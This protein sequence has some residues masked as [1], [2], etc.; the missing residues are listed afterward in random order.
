MNVDSMVIEVT[1]R[2]QLE[3]EHC[4]RG[5]AQSPDIELGYVAA[6]FSKVQ[7]INTITFSGGEPSL[8]PEKLEMIRKLAE[9]H[10]VDIGNFYIATNAAKNNQYKRFLSACFNWYLYCS[11]NEVSAVHWSNDSYHQ[12]DPDNVKMLSCLSFASARYS[13]RRKPL[14]YLAEGRA[15]DNGIGENAVH[16]YALDIEDDTV[17]GNIYLNCLGQ[18]IHGCDWSYANQQEHVICDVY[19][20]SIE[21]I[22]K[23]IEK[24]AEI[25]EI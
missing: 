11:D 15:A 6:L 22:K 17:M 4:L 24:E 5:D 21:A 2:C 20:L 14:T 10:H 25:L 19:D 7:A 12:L 16:E 3:C 8:V 18:I 13:D 1:R 23:Y 9:K